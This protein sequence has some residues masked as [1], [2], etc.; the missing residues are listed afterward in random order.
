LGKTEFRAFQA[1]PRG[2][3][4]GSCVF[5]VEG[6]SGSDDAAQVIDLADVPVQ[7]PV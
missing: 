1:S 3:L 5:Y 4:E 6:R 7:M 2:E